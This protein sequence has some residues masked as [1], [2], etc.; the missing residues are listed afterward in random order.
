MDKYTED[1]KSFILEHKNDL[2]RP[3][4]EAYMKHKFPFLGIKA[5]ERVQLTKQFIKMNGDP[6]EL[7]IIREIWDLAGREFQYIALA[8][9]DRQYK[10]A[11]KE[12]IIFYESLVVDKSWWDTVDTLA[13]RLIC[14]HFQT[15]PELI[16]EYAEK[17]IKSENMW[18]NRAAILFQMKYKDK[19]D[20]ERLFRYCQ[21][22]S[23]S[24][25]F[26]IQKAIGWALREYSYINSDAVQKFIQ[27]TNLAPL[28][29][30]EG[31]KNIDKLRKQ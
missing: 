20:Q 7:N 10:K 27:N 9:L 23:N 11:E 18:L 14:F 29:K 19:T 3:A 22:M 13:G 26:F 2:N 25:E 6:T 16:E 17:W 4:M 28:S 12:R 24:K 5:P 8:L 31:M 1:L 30:R 21:L 15:Y